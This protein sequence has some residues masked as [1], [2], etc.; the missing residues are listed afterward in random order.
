M[1]S[2]SASSAATSESEIISAGEAWFELSLA[3][4]T[5]ASLEID[6]KMKRHASETRRAFVSRAWRKTGYAKR[7]RLFCTDTT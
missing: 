5:F 2:S 4:G 7:K 6:H 3:S 1:Q